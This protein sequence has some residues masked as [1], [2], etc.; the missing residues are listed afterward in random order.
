M[1]LPSYLADIEEKATDN[2]ALAG[3]FAHGTAGAAG[4]G[5]FLRAQRATTAEHKARRTEAEARKREDRARSFVDDMLA[6]RAETAN[7][8][9]LRRR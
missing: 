1:G 6:W 9:P 7:V 2:R 8:Q 4:M 3:L 5:S